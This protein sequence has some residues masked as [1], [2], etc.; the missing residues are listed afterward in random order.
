VRSLTAL[1]FVVASLPTAATAELAFLANGRTL[2]IKGHRI[3]GDRMTLELRAG[4]EVSCPS[5]LVVRVAADEMPYPEPS[6]GTTL[7]AQEPAAVPRALGG[8]YARLI[9]TSAT[10]HGVDPN[11]VH[12][13]IRAESNYEPRARSRRGARGL[14]QLMPSTLKAYAVANAYDPAA[15]IE[16]G[17]RHLR[18]LLDRYVLDQAL[19]AYNAGEGAVQRY[20]GVPPY[21][22]TRA[23]VTRVLATLPAAPVAR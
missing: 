4:G 1:A 6:A 18:A 20:G 3:E 7:P 21:R 15:N 23:Y 9:A 16:A 14:M 5:A 12:A 2:S 13:V 8:P 17:T 19:A 10:R 22:E 11:L